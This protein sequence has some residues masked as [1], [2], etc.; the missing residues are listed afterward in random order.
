MKNLKLDK[1]TSP[2]KDKGNGFTNIDKILKP[3][4]KLQTL[5]KSMKTD[6]TTKKGW[7]VN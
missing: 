2:R 6:T 7:K 1:I 4:D 5:E 3:S